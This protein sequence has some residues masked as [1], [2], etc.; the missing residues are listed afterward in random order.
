M[1]FIPKQ[2]L[3]KKARRA[4]DA[5]RRATWDGLNPVTRQAVS[6]KAYDRKKPAGFDEDRPGGLFPR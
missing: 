6:K 1:K 5:K 4:L 3:S 2:K